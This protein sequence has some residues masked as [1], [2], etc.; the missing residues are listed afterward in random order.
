MVAVNSTF[1]LLIETLKS[2]PS[3]VPFKS[4]VEYSVHVVVELS[5]V[6]ITTPVLVALEPLTT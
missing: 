1:G 2:I 3:V 5:Q 6:A 4:G